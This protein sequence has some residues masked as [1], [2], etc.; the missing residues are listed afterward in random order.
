MNQDLEKGLERK[1][2]IGLLLTVALILLTGLYLL[3][4]SARMRG[5]EARFTRRAMM[6]GAHI[7][8]V[9]CYLCHGLRGE[10]VTAPPLAGKRFK[11]E[12]E[13]TKRITRGGVVMPAFGQEDGGALTWYQVH[14]LVAFL[15]NWDEALL[16]EVQHELE[17]QDLT[18]PTPAPP[19]PAA[20]PLERGQALFAARG[21]GACHTI[22]DTAAKGTLGPELTQVGT[23]AG[24]RQPSLSAKEYLQEALEQPNAFLV[25]GFPPGMM[26]P[27][28][29][30]K[31]DLEGLVEYL[32]TLK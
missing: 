22:K 23:V 12:K 5:A 9:Q 2:L 7:F 11:E 29:L 24:T 31:E 15:M 16:E 4:E 19:P 21:C 3:T 6:E 26:P 32:L 30:S 18:F 13:L 27:Q 1:F 14:D 28:K 25:S 10:G 20:T 8:L 17:A